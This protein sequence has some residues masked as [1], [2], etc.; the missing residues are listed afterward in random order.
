MGN[1][2]V[3]ADQLD[4]EIKKI[5]AEYNYDVQVKCNEATKE[6]A[7]WGAEQLKFDARNAGIKGRKYVNSFYAKQLK[8]KRGRLK[9]A[10]FGGQII[11]ETWVIASKQYRIAHLLEHGHFVKSHGK[12]TGFR[13]EAHHHWTDVEKQTI[14]LLDGKV[15]AIIEGMN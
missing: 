15:R 11:G 2:K 10:T 13:A 8:T 14:D 4:F 12:L 3:S 9:Y 7:E 6:V 5:L 1:I